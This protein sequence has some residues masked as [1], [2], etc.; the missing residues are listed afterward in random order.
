[1]DEFNNSFLLNVL[2]GFGLALLVSFAWV[3]FG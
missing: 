1:M 2:I 3:W